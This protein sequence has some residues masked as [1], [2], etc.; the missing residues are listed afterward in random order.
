MNSMS[1]TPLWPV[2]LAWYRAHRRPLAWRAP[3][4]SAW[5]VLLSEVMSQQTPVSRVEPLW[6]SWLARWPTPAD[7]AAAPTADILRA[8]GNLGYPRRALRLKE[9]AI[10]IVERH[11]G[12]V[13]ADVASLL[14]LPGIGDYTARAVAAFAFGVRTPVIDTNVRRVLG[15]LLD[16]EHTVAR[17]STT[18]GELLRLEALLPAADAPEVSEALIEFGALV[19]TTTPR[20]D[21]CPISGQCA[22]VAAGR[23]APTVRKKVQGYAGT[24]RQVRGIV[25]AAVRSLPAGKGLPLVETTSLWSDTS[26]L[27]RAIAG[28]ISDGLLVQH[29]RELHLP[30]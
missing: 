16:G 19:C 2:L 3:G 4:T 25:L 12:Q 13:P 18:K 7:L 23:P 11:G 21:Q 1:I 29:T 28:L 8:W 15:R 10:A 6:E 24:D 17:S 27:E 26:Q 5:G 30:A 20:C 9:C 14:A 22:W